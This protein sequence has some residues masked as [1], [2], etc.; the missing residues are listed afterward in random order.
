[1][2]LAGDLGQAH[3]VAVFGAA[4]VE[5]VL[6]LLIWSRLIILIIVVP[7][8]FLVAQVVGNLSLQLLLFGIALDRWILDQLYVAASISLRTLVPALPVDTQVAGVLRVLAKLRLLD[9]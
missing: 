1:L 5:V 7:S 2:A 4:G 9:L 8:A 3:A 6:R